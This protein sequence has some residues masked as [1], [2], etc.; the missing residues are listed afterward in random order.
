VEVIEG[1]FVLDITTENKLDSIDG[2][3]VLHNNP[4][5]Q[6]HNKPV[7]HVETMSTGNK[8]KA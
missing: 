8:I 6:D 7:E 1:N 2:N 3:L 5:V 4:R